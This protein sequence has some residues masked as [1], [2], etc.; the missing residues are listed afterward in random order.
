VNY[1]HRNIEQTVQ[2][3]KT[4]FPAV[5]LT[6]PRQSGKSTTLKRL[7]TDYTY[8]TFDDPVN[9]E[10][11]NHDPKGFLQQ[12]P[13]RIIFDEAQKVPELFHYL[14][15]EID[16]DRGNYGKYLLTGSS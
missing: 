11:F 2:T 4:L 13:D 14:K 5:A 3:Y 10:F 9:L 1:L 8:I 15:I 16:K 7:L 12:Y 6:G